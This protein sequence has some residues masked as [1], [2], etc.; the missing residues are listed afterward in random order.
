M[1]HFE[2]IVLG[3][4]PAGEKGAAQFRH[5]LVEVVHV[6][7]TGRRRIRARGPGGLGTRARP[8]PLSLGHRVTSW[9]APTR[10]PA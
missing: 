9:A 1:E 2:L 8:A 10:C 7:G 6:A 4:G 5:A 3:C